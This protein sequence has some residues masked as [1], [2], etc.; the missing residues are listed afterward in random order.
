MH[1]A[2]KLLVK[3]FLPAEQKDLGSKKNVKPPRWIRQK[4]SILHH[5]A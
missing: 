3:V 1:R 5:C 4:Q 2:A